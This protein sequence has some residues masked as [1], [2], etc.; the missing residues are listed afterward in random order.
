MSSPSV[1]KMVKKLDENHY[2]S[3][4]KYIG[5][6]LTAD[7]TTI[8]KNIHEKYSQ[9]GEFL[10]SIGVVDNVVHLDAEGIE[11]HLHPRTIKRQELLIFW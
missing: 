5:L 8:A 7:G 9:F 3:Y 4:Q 6:K 10:K 1:T 11:H 2:L